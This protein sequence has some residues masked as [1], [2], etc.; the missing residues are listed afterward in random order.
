[1]RVAYARDL[2]LRDG[3][4]RLCALGSYMGFSGQIACVREA[5]FTP[6]ALG[7]HLDGS[8]VLP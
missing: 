6:F 5:V 8:I 2:W 7:Y 3:A 1:M 4:N